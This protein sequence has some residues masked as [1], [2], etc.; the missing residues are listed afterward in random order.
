MLIEGVLVV[1]EL[2]PNKLVPV[3]LEK[4]WREIVAGKPDINANI[5]TLHLCDKETF[6]N[7]SLAPLVEEK[8]TKRQ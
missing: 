4:L 2:V 3:V 6:W 7:I 1:L 5:K 8:S